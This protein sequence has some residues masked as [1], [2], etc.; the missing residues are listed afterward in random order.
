MADINTVLTKI[1]DAQNEA[2]DVAGLPHLV[3]QIA[4]LQTQLAALSASA[5]ALQA[6]IDAAK[7]ALG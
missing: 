5:S 1:A 7:A 4:A 2:L 3:D 6:K